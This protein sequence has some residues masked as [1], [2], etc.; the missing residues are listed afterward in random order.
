VINQMGTYARSRQ[1]IACAMEYTR[2][3]LSLLSSSSSRG[4]WKFYY[5]RNCIVLSCTYIRLEQQRRR[6]AFSF[7]VRAS[8]WGGEVIS[9]NA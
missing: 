8:L 3:P 2:L 4:I 9:I 6:V 7:R 5:A 1:I